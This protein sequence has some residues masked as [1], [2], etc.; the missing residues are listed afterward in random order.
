MDQPLKKILW[1]QFG[2]AVLMLENAIIACP[3]D[4]W[5]KPSQFWYNSYHTLF[6][7]DYYSSLAPDQFHP[8]APFTL[9]EFDSSGGLPDRVYQ[10]TE[11]LSYLAFG[12]KKAYD[13]ITGFTVETINHRFINV[14]KDYSML[15]IVIYN[16]RH[17]QHHAAQL[18]MLLRQNNAV[19]PNWVSDAE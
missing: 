13:L 16:M 15:E 4:L 12:R 9:S 11:L 1:K 14:A 2:A 19:V 3:E 8:P 6:Y 10:K 18:N 7:L 5:D 17:I